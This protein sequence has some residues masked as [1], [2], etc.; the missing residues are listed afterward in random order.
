MGFLSHALA[1][2]LSGAGPGAE[3][4]PIVRTTLL[5]S[6]V[7]T[8]FALTVLVQSIPGELI[9]RLSLGLIAGVL[10]SAPFQVFGSRIAS[11]VRHL[12]ALS[13]LLG[14]L[15]LMSLLYPP[16]VYLVG[17]CLALSLRT[18]L[19][20][21]ELRLA[22]LVGASYT[23]SCM[24]EASLEEDEWRPV[25]QVVVAWSVFLAASIL[26]GWIVRD[27]LL[28]VELASLPTLS[29]LAVSL[30][31]N[32][33]GRAVPPREPSLGYVI[34]SV[35][36]AVAALLDLLILMISS[37]AYYLAVFFDKLLI[38]SEYGFPYPPLDVP[39][40]LGMLPLMAGTF[41]SGCFWASVGDDLSRA[42]EAG[43]DEFRK[44][45][46]R[47]RSEFRRGVG[48][49]LLLSGA[50]LIELTLAV[51]PHAG[52]MGYISGPLGASLIAL[53]VWGLRTRVG[54]EVAPPLAG[55]AALSLP[56]WGWEVSRVSADLMLLYSLGSV[57]GAL[58]VYI[59]SQLA[60]FRRE[61][62]A[63]AALFLVPLLELLVARWWGV[64][65]VAVGYLLGSGASAAVHLLT[66]VRMWGNLR[67]ELYRV[68]S[69]SSHLSY[70]VEVPRYGGEKP[71]SK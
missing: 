39:S 17:W 53:A 69:Y 32:V 38:W 13:P 58:V 55:T 40:L 67:E 25:A 50:I 66:A 56:A 37:V 60:A 35:I 34:G 24:V 31:L 28:A 23:L 18:Q 43:R 10:A 54:L 27:T 1:R 47:V 61:E 16:S 36:V 49:T 71:W 30:A 65:R 46:R 70:V 15:I 41:A 7:W 68:L 4:R 21:E 59:Y 26:I 64:D 22:G 48:L 44:I 33:R 63:T 11:D 57:P 45:R 12:G 29:V 8:V 6:P 9:P 2:A 14:T 3:M 52:W 19:S 42:Y 20:P 5:L 62:E 51:G